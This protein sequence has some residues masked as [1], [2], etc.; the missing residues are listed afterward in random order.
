M[1]EPDRARARRLAQESL[2]RG[3]AIGWFDAFY[4]AAD[5]D[6][7]QIPWADL[8][9]NPHLVVWFS[10]RQA[11]PEGQRVLVVGCGLGD[12]AEWLAARGYRVTAFDVAARAIEWCR[13]RFPA[14]LVDY[15]V[16]DLLNPPPAWQAAFDLVIEIYT[17]QVL[18]NDLRTR[19]SEA[20][21]GFVADG[22]TLL[23]IVRGRELSDN[24]GAMPW[25]LT[26][27]DLTRFNRRGLETVAFEDFLD[28]HEPDVRRFRVEFRRQA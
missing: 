17:L 11:A 8:H 7:S 13:G 28:P 23:V 1:N 16:A 24:P 15:H 27:D 2:A 12:D 5:G 21:A 26:L 14:S 22:G 20:L 18:P 4:D 25:P 9:A 3:D 19:A 6:P 10:G